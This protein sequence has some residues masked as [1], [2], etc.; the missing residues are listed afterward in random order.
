MRSSPMVYQHGITLDF[1]RPGKPTDNTF[2][3]KLQRSLPDR[4]PQHF[5]FL[6]LSDGEEKVEAWRRFIRRNSRSGERQ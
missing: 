6:S 5:S 2:I 4:M 1:S 3:E